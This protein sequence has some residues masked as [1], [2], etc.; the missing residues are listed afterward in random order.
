MWGALCYLQKEKNHRSKKR[1]RHFA[2][3]AA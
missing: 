2:T 1:Q 3:L